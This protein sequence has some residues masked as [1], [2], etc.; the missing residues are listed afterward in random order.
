MS[1]LGAMD[2]ERHWKPEV[3]NERGGRALTRRGYRTEAAR[4]HRQSE[5]AINTAEA[6][7]GNIAEPVEQWAVLPPQAADFLRSLG[8]PI[9][10]KSG[11]NA[12]LMH[13]SKQHTWSARQ[14][15]EA[16]GMN[17]TESILSSETRARYSAHGHQVSTGQ[18]MQAIA[19]RPR[20]KYQMTEAGRR[21]LAD[22]LSRWE[23]QNPEDAA[24]VRAD[25]SRTGLSR[26]RSPESAIKRAASMRAT[27][28][29]NPHLV[30]AFVE[31]M[32]S[33]AAKEARAVALGSR[34]HGTRAVG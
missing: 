25:A 13:V 7:T 11:L 8:C 14:V 20:K 29:A 31:R 27:L 1:N 17:S 6:L 5:G 19:T 24:R 21:A 22:N 26:A 23:A 12:P 18:D 2:P 33:D 10:G 30:D 4:V 28:T 34:R 32:A 15:R 9:C 3:D 16:C